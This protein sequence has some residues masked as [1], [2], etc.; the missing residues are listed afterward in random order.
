MLSIT[1][2]E[3]MLNWLERENVINLLTPGWLLM[4]T[5]ALSL[6]SPMHTSVPLMFPPQ[7]LPSDLIPQYPMLPLRWDHSKCMIL[8]TQIPNWL[9]QELSSK[10]QTLSSSL[11][12]VTRLL[13][14]ETIA[15]SYQILSP[16]VRRLHQWL[17]SCLFLLLEY[18]LHHG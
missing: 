9:L 1:L 3:L 5:N 14:I 12:S 6:K 16:C 13:W 18:H 8:L 11:L 7:G 10:D 4:D 2:E 15:I 17:L